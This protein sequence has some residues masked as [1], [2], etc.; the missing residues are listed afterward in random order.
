MSAYLRLAKTCIAR[1]VALCLVP[2]A[3]ALESLMPTSLD[4][5]HCDQ[6]FAHFPDA[7][8]I[9]D[10]SAVFI[11]RAV[12]NQRQCYSG[13][14]KR[15]CVK[16]QALVTTKGLCVHLSDV[17]RGNVH[18]KAIFDQSE[19]IAFLTEQGED[20]LP[21]RRQMMSDLGYV[22]ISGMRGSRAPVRGRLCR[23]G[24]GLGLGVGVG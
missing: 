12:H 21:V 9:V 5:V 18:N 8:A 22:G 11:H 24:A 16:V 4:D 2:V 7:F 15:H 1:T 14:F 23:S 10:A 6:L 19:V 20:E 17:F 13:K 3:E